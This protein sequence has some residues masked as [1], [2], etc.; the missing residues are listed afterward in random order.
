MQIVDEG[1]IREVTTEDLI[2]AHVWA[3]DKVGE[4]IDGKIYW[5]QINEDTRGYCA[6]WTKLVDGKIHFVAWDGGSKPETEE[7]E[8][9]PHIFDAYNDFIEMLTEGN[10]D[11][12][13]DDLD[14]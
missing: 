13:D 5:E 6:G 7:D 10:E 4:V 2:Q 11:D 1:V 9:E 12:E 14:E 3:G 8:D